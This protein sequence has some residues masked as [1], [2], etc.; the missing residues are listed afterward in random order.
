MLL[1]RPLLRINHPRQYH[2]HLPVFF[3]F[4]VSNLGGLLTPL[5]DPPLFLGFLRGVDFFFT[6][7]LWPHWL[8]AVGGVLLVF[9]VWDA[10]CYWR[11]A[12]TVAAEGHESV[13]AV[14]GLQNV[15]FLMGI[16]AAV[17][18]KSP[19]VYE[20]L[21]EQ[22]LHEL[23]VALLP[24]GLMALMA[25]LSL[26]FTP[27]RLREHNEFTWEA[28]VEVA[29]L[30]LGIFITMVPALILLDR[31]GAELGLTEPWHYFWATGSLSAFLDN[32]P[33][34]LT[35][36]TIAAH[37]RPLS[38]LATE[39][40]AILQAI[41]AGAVFLGA[42]TYIGNGP[43]FMVK[44]LAEG[45][46]YKMPSFFGYLLYACAILGPIFVIVTLLFFAG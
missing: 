45:M 3:I 41:S 1:I 34:Y 5:G 6:A 17:L 18:V 25:I 8:T 2:S 28:L 9:F 32:A 27:T 42:M 19:D 38:V 37:G 13:L 14:K 4:A 12:A 26:A 43:N 40:P 29:V 44:A 46:G 30:F 10:V 22:G 33:T 35:F 21:K 24:S 7:S 23:V 16:V 31:H 39:E 11:E 15:L 20:F 36:A